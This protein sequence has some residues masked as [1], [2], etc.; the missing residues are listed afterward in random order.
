MY[1]TKKMKT[2]KKTPNKLKEYLI[3][4][5]FDGNDSFTVKAKDLQEAYYKALEELGWWVSKSD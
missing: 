5:D 1:L 3:V 2:S 4:N